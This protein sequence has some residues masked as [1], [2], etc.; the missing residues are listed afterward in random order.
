MQTE[1]D[2]QAIVAGAEIGSAGGN[3]NG[4]FLHGYAAATRV[5]G[6]DG[7]KVIAAV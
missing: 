4:N 5:V 2:A 1:R 7:A 3:T 6:L